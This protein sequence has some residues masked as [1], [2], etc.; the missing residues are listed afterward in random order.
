M[1]FRRAMSKGGLERLSIQLDP[2]TRKR[3]DEAAALDGISR[4]FMAA[5]LIQEALEA[6]M[7]RQ[8]IEAVS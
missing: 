1:G 2:L 3:V 4:S 6:H 8:P 5:R 7:K